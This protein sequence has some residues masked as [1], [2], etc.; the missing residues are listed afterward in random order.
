MSVLF[1]KPMTADDLLTVGK[2]I[3]DLTRVFNLRAGFGYEDDTLPLR[4]F[5][6]PI[7]SGPSKGQII[8]KSAFEKMKQEYYV[9]Q[10][11][12][13]KE[14]GPLTFTEDYLFT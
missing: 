13:E 6:D 11:W 7:P 8:N 2:R 1:E 5:E 12:D 3:W 4:L 9:H 14:G 10:G